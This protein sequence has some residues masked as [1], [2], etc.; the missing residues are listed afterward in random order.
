MTNA[1][2]TSTAASGTATASLR[3]LTRP[4]YC[5][6]AW[7]AEAFGKR[8]PV[9][10]ADAPHGQLVDEMQFAW[11]GGGAERGLDVRAQLLQ[12]QLARRNHGGLHPLAEPPIGHAEHRALHD[13][14][15]PENLG[16]DDLRQH[17]QAAGA[18]A[19]VEAP[20]HGQHTGRV[21]TARVIGQK[22][23]RL[24]ER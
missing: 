21:D 24:A 5:P 4:P 3:T 15:M 12:R 20:V 7:S 14:R 17:G 13:G 22:P 6:R 19:L 16:F 2:A 9:D 11:R 1:A 10:L 23:A 18:D 8:A